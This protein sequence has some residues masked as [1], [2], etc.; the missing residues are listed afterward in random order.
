MCFGQTGVIAV[1]LTSCIEKTTWDLFLTYSF[2]PTTQSDCDVDDDDDDEEE[3]E[4]DHDD[5]HSPKPL[6]DRG[7]L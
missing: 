2:F 5:Y 4:E 1:C 6:F 3:E 7:L